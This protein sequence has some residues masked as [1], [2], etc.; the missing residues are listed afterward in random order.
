MN[1]QI[2]QA[3]R[4]RLRDHTMSLITKCYRR[5]VRSALIGATMAPLCAA[6]ALRGLWIH[7]WTS[8]ILWLVAA[9]VFASIA[10]TEYRD[11]KK[12]NKLRKEIQS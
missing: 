7:Y 9:I 6:I 4:S 3:A 8:S 10:Y 11:A 1:E 2:D 12:W 5:S